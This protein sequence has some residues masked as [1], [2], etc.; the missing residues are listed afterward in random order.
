MPFTTSGQETEWALFLQPQS[1]HGATGHRTIE[2]R[3]N[4][5]LKT[6]SQSFMQFTN[7]V[8]HLIGH[9]SQIKVGIYD[10]DL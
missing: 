5:S 7:N 10:H 6:T 4:H 1:P 9:I 3:Y 2:N 8:Y